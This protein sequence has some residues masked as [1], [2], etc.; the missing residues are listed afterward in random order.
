MEHQRLLLAVFVVTLVL[1]SGCV[2]M[3]FTTSVNSAGD[4]DKFQIQLNMTTAMYAMLDTAAIQT[5][6][7][8]FKESM[9]HPQNISGPDPEFDVQEEWDRENS[10]VKFTMTARHPATLIHDKNLSVVQDGEYLIFRHDLSS[11][12]EPTQESFDNPFASQME[13]LFTVSYYLTMPGEIVESN[14]DTV[15]GTTAEW[16]RTSSQMP[17]IY[18]KSKVSAVS[19]LVVVGLGILAFVGIVGLGFAGSRRRKRSRS[20]SILGPE[21][22]PPQPNQWS[23]TPPPAPRRQSP[24]RVVS[25]KAEGIPYVSYSQTRYTRSPTTVS[26][27]RDTSERLL[28]IFLVGGTILLVG[29]FG[30]AMLQS[31]L[32][33]AEGATAPPE[34]QMVVE[35]T[36][37]PLPTTAPMVA[38]ITAT[39]RSHPAK[40]LSPYSE[41]PDAITANPYATK[42]V[43][44][45]YRVGEEPPSGSSI[46]VYVTPYPIET[47]PAIIPIATPPTT[48]L[49]RTTTPPTTVAPK[50]TTVSPTPPT[51]VAPKT[52]TVSPTPPPPSPCNCDADTYNCGDALAQTCYGYCL[53][54]GKG[55][56]HKLD[57]DNDGVPCE[58]ESTPSL[59]TPDR[60]TST[61]TPVAPPEPTTYTITVISQGIGSVTPSG[62]VTVTEG[63]SVT[64]SMIPDP[65]IVTPGATQSG[66]FVYNLVQVDP[67]SMEIPDYADPKR[68]VE[69]W[70]P[71]SHQGSFTPS[72]TFE[73][74]QSD[75]TLWVVFYRGPYMVC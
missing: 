12:A 67:T 4:I 11:S 59:P 13:S 63:E 44:P 25:S 45:G 38:P 55:D 64:F 51:T 69:P 26:K 61:S 1:A 7:S 27:K 39:Q 41:D 50:T 62:K 10:R 65:S 8:S 46:M 2:D 20:M 19:P 31:F 52:T 35:T 37:S 17:S 29:L 15:H 40:T 48:A 66:S 60:N 18:A 36:R 57:A 43:A 33:G 70:G 21:A 54:Q 6:S 34:A 73:N 58:G 3:A 32:T 16:H 75:H 5:G 42:Y 71:N 53:A 9:E 49:S 47:A 74:V 14:A 56:V 68:T 72:Y 30:A 24:Y 23:P 22:I 28:Q